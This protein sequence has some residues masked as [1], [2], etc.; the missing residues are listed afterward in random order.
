MENRKIRSK[1]TELRIIKINIKAK[2]KLEKNKLM[3]HHNNV[4]TR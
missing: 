3:K 1:R 4:G 2:T